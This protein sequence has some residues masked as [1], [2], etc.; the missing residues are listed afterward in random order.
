M[1][2]PQFRCILSLTVACIALAVP[3]GAS[4]ATVVNG[5]FETGN[6]NGW[7]QFSQTEAG[8][9]FTY[10]KEGAEEEG[11]FPPPTGRF[12]AADDQGS[13]DLDSTR[14]SPWSRAS[15]TSSP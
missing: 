6:L 11:F 1:S 7:Q 10:E 12:A 4:G 5:N 9:W 13:P 15:P 2:R 14:T 8:E 3:A